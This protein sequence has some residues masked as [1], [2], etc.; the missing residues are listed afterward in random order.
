MLL[1]E[2]RL[3][4]QIHPVRV[5]GAG[6]GQTREVGLRGRAVHFALEVLHHR[7]EVA[8]GF[9]HHALQLVLEVLL[10]V[11]HIDVIHQE[12]E[13][14]LVAVVDVRASAPA[15]FGRDDNHAVGAA[16][17]VNRRGR[18][19]FQHLDVGDVVGVERREIGRLH[20][21]AVHNI[22]R[23]V[24]TVDRSCTADADRQIVAARLS[25]TAGDHHTGRLALQS[26]FER[27][28]RLKFELLALHLRKGSRGLG[29]A[30]G[31]VTYAHDL[32]EPLGVLFESDFDRRARSDGYLLRTVTYIR[33]GENGVVRTSD[34]CNAIDIG[35]GARYGSLD[36]DTR[37]DYRPRLVNDNHRTRGGRLLLLRRHGQSR[38]QGEQNHTNRV[39]V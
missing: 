29:A 36:H 19:V 15:A 3:G 24:A 39:K 38:Q 11:H 25:R 22:K 4:H 27:R 14:E 28:R 1:Q 35:R 13:T 30:Y 7:I 20:H 18:S 26:V 5:G 2:T 10:A 16:R 23:S 32:I 33:Y 6:L 12:R 31:V 17:T 34:S 37:T 21:H 8:V 9:R